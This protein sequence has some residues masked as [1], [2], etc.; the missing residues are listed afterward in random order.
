MGA[1]G[2]RITFDGILLTG[3]GIE[4]RGTFDEMIIRHCTL[5]P[6]WSLHADAK[7]RRPAEP[8]LSFIKA[9]AR[10]RI[11]RCI[12]GAIHATQEDVPADP[13]AI[14]IT[15]SIVDATSRELN[16]IGGPE[17]A[18]AS[19]ALNVIRCTIV[20]RVHA[21]SIDLAENCVFAGHVRVARRQSGCMRYCY[22]PP[23]SHTPS[24]YRCQPDLVD[25]ALDDSMAPEHLSRSERN[26]VRQAEWLRVAPQFVTTRYGEPAY[27]R[28]ADGCAEEVTRGAED[29]AEIG[30]FHSLFEPQRVDNLR[31]RLAEYVPA[32]TDVGIIFAS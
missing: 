7:L 31:Q 14:W 16:A 17:A 19:V 4:V 10:V 28:L 6:G 30:V 26:I 29:R 25:K 24:R 20:G 1:P 27:C 23:K 8:S 18:F 32:G 9:S 3:R 2:S 13:V 15:D 21:H 11:D 22:V 12:I 5:V